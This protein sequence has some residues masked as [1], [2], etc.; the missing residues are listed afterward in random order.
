MAGR[1]GNDSDDD[2]EATRKKGTNIY[3]GATWPP[4]GD[5]NPTKIEG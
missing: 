5:G 1:A 2:D 3:Y 4:S